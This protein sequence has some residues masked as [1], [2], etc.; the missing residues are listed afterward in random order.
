[1]CLINLKLLD[2]N[3]AW[4]TSE[5]SFKSTND[6]SEG[7]F[8]LKRKEQIFFLFTPQEWHLEFPFCFVGYLKFSHLVCLIII[9]KEARGLSKLMALSLFHFLKSQSN[10]KKNTYM[11]TFNETSCSTTSV[12]IHFVI[13]ILSCSKQFQSFLF[14]RKH[15]DWFIW[16]KKTSFIISNRWYS[17]I[18]LTVWACLHQAFC[19]FLFISNP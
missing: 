12:Q 8:S 6:I 10:G 1:M 7:G 18:L 2:G 11:L 3:N 16:R 19:F 5:G 9:T 13:S 4:F 15:I 17:F 14:Q